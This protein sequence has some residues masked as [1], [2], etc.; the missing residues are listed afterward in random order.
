MTFERRLVAGYD[1]VIR[2]IHSTSDCVVVSDTIRPVLNPA[3]HDANAMDF[4]NNEDGTLSIENPV[5]DATYTLY[6][7]ANNELTVIE[8]AILHDGTNLLHGR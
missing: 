7:N 3:P 5:A 8:P 6:H 1:Y 4:V 2:A